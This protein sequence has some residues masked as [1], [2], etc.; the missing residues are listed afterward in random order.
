MRLTKHNGV[1][2]IEGSP[3]S[4]K[5]LGHVD[6]KLG[7]AL[8]N[9]QLK[10]LDDLKTVIAQEVIKRGGNALVKFCYG[11]KT[12]GFWKSLFQLDRVSWYG[13]GDAAS[14]DTTNLD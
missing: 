3:D 10:N 11:Q 13:H 9:S 14:I 8:V 7:G 6:I 5:S 4:Y 1:Y 2:F 12:G